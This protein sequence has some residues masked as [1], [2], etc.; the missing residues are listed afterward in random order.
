[1]SEPVI[2]SAV[3]IS[4]GQIINGNQSYTVVAR[5]L[6]NTLYYTIFVCKPNYTDTIENAFKKLLPIQIKE[7]ETSG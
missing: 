2:L 4:K 3:G 1:M 7:E 5:D 6:D